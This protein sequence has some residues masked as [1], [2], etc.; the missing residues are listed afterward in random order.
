MKSLFEC[1]FK[2]KVPVLLSTINNWFKNREIQSKLESFSMQN[3]F[4][5]LNADISGYDH[6]SEAPLYM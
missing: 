4:V 1:D 6:L 3:N 5:S 2:G